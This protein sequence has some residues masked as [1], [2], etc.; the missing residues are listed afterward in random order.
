MNK[1]RVALQPTK[2]AMTGYTPVGGVTIQL[3]A[4]GPPRS[5]VTTSPQAAKLELIEIPGAG[6]ATKTSRVLLS[7]DGT[8]VD[9]SGKPFFDSGRNQPTTAFNLSSSDFAI[10]MA[11]DPDNFNVLTNPVLVLPWESSAENFNMEVRARLSITGTVEADVG[12]NDTLDLRMEHKAVPD[13]GTNTQDTSDCIGIGT[14]YPTKHDFMKPGQRIPFAGKMMRVFVDDRLL[15]AVNKA[16]PGSLNLAQFSTSLSTIMVDAGFTAPTVTQFTVGDPAAS[17]VWTRLSGQVVAKGVTDRT[18]ISPPDGVSI[19]FFDFWVFA[20]T[21]GSP[22]SGEGGDSETLNPNGQVNIAAGTKRVITPIIIFVRQSTPFAKSLSTTVASDVPN[23]VATIIAHEIGHGLG[24]R[25]G[26]RF[27]I[28]AGTYKVASQ[29]GTM[30]GQ[31]SN[32]T[33]HAQAQLFGP[34]HK[35][36]LKKFYL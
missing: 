17:A 11:F 26:L 21:T 18:A 16:A 32:S 34:V 27:D 29:I 22:T 12:Q 1:V 6:D 7:V 31:F 2:K 4:N 33:G 5:A 14:V 35:D 9:K 13:D 15:P 24:L 30:T 36:L 25:H 28:G 10:D 3:T 19:P 8:I 20:D 23:A